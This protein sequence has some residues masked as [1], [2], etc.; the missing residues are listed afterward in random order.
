MFGLVEQDGKT[1]LA[2]GIHDNAWAVRQLV[3]DTVKNYSPAQWNF[4]FTHA[5][6]GEGVERDRTFSELLVDVANQ[7]GATLVTVVLRCSETE[8]LKRVRHSGRSLRMKATD[9]RISKLAALPDYVPPGITNPV[10][11]DTTDLQPEE[12]VDFILRR[13]P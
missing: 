8:L 4:G 2:K 7:R 13:A 11:I 6:I 3:L 12:V 5:A 10:V 9:P 1:P